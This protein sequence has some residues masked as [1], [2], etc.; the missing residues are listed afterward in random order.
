M[1]KGRAAALIAAVT[2]VKDYARQNPDKAE[3]VIGK[4][5][6]FV[7]SRA[8]AQHA[9]KVDQSGDAL[10]KGLGLSPHGPAGGQ[11]GGPSGG[12]VPPPR[13]SPGSAA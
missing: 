9:A 10:R 2:K 3:Q 7:R 4:L 6:G 1:A 11:A 13:P 5:E 12:Q 8:G